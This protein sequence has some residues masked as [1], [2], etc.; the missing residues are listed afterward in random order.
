MGHTIFTSQS[1][2]NSAAQY[3]FIIYIASKF[4]VLL[5]ATLY[6]TYNS[7]TI[8]I[9][10]YIEFEFLSSID[11]YNCSIVFLLIVTVTVVFSVILSLSVESLSPSMSPDLQRV[12]S[13]LQIV[14]STLRIVFSTLQK[15][16]R[17]SGVC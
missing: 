13:T 1:P 2:K 4:V 5:L 11:Y 12:S 16:W 6:N 7:I 17:L 9:V 10:C 3:F 15:V 14:S 8:T